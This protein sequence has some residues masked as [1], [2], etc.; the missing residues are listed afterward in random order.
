[1]AEAG[2][3]PVL[4][5]ARA[6]LYLHA[7]EDRKAAFPDV[8]LTM[9]AVLGMMNSVIN[10]RAADQDANLARIAAELS[11]LVVAGLGKPVP[12]RKRS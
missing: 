12:A 8:R 9:L 11:Q 5:R 3:E 10:W 6:L 4:L 2:R 1:M 7:D